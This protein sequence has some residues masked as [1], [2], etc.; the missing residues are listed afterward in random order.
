[1]GVRLCIFLLCFCVLS[2][3]SGSGSNGT[4][5]LRFV[6]G[7]PDAPQVNLL[8]DG[9]SVASTL[10]YANATGYISVRV[11]S[12]HVQVVPA[13][14]GSAILDT[15]VSITSS[16]N[17]TLI[18]TGAAA[19]TQSVLLTDTSTT[20]TAG[21]QSVRVVNAATAIAAADV[22][23]VPAGTSI[24]ALSPTSANLAFNANTGYQLLPSGA[25]QVLLTA[26]GTKNSFLDTGA[27]STSTTSTQNQTVIVLDGA[28]TGFTFTV[29]TDQ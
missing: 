2:G 4:G 29:L 10:G 28:G 13:N 21:D 12:R 7:S 25:Y 27:L 19:S 16:G 18:M 5:N 3:C 20:S 6:Q 17:Q 26:P 22:Y 24:A 11:G 9:K 15:S 1:M 14:G 23:I 8:V